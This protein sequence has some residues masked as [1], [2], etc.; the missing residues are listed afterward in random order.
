MAGKNDQQQ[1]AVVPF[2]YCFLAGQLDMQH[3]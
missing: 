2:A 1:E 3:L